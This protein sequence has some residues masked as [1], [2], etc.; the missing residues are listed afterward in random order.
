M[1]VATLQLKSSSSSGLYSSASK[2][3]T[4]CGAPTSSCSIVTIGG[5]DTGGAW[6]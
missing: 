3:I 6:S 5:F 1:Y 2:A 4:I